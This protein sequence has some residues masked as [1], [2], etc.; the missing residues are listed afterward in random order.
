MAK[1]A[2][3]EKQAQQPAVQRENIFWKPRSASCRHHA[4]A[5]IWHNSRWIASVT[6]DRSTNYQMQTDANQ[7]LQGIL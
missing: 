2:G 7:E 5:E 4:P 1:A 6:I 3:N